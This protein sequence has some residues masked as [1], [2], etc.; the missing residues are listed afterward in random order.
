[1]NL[2]DLS[3]LPA[4]VAVETLSYEDELSAMKADLV[5]MTAPDQQESMIKTLSLE[6]EPLT[7]LLQVFAYRMILVRQEFNDRSKALLIAYAAGADLDHIGVTYY[8]TQRRVL[9]AADDTTD[10][11]TE[12]VLESDASYK[13]R[14][15]LAQDGYS[16]AGAVKAYQFHAKGA[17]PGILDVK[18]ENAGGGRVRVTV[19]YAAGDGTVPPAVID[20]VSQALNGETTRPM[21]DTVQVVPAEIGRYVVRARALSPGGPTSD[22]LVA[23]AVAGCRRFVEKKRLIGEGIEL[24]QLKR[25]IWAEQLVDVELLEPA[26]DMTATPGKSWYCESIEILPS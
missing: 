2:I 8:S 6:S 17:D 21:N 1:M 23:E 9:I 25:S 24:D 7:K 3:Q 16:T 15:L 26:Q 11:P 5:A 20:A 22:L 18:P 12:A 13:S 19:L 14:L 4:P 10:P